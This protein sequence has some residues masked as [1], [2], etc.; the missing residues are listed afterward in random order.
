MPMK[1]RLR[2]EEARRR[3]R[4]Q[5][6]KDRSWEDS[7]ERPYLLPTPCVPRV[8]YDYVAIDCEKIVVEARI[9]SEKERVASVSIV[10]KNGVP[11]YDVFISTP[12]DCHFNKKSRPHCPVTDQQFAIAKRCENTDFDHVRSEVLDILHR[13]NKY[14]NYSYSFYFFFKGGGDRH[15]NQKEIVWKV[16]NKFRL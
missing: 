5:K 11:V 1:N 6:K 14:I 2:G 3:R 16:S 12:S 13:Y 4:H 9:P 15:I 7:P 10:D 8:R